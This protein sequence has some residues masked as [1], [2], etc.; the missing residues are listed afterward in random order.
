MG[1]KKN[2]LANAEFYLV[3][4]MYAF[5]GLLVWQISKIHILESRMLPMVALIISAASA[6]WN[7]F[8]MV[9]GRGE[10]VSLKAVGMRPKEI[11]IFLLLLAANPL[12]D[13]LGFYCTI[14]LFSLGVIYVLKMPLTVKEAVKGLVYISVMMGLVYLCFTVALGMVTPAGLLI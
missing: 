8:L 13:F 9:G 6:S 4:M 1:N 5:C 3:L 10:F 2:L 14:F 11:G 7:L 12:Y